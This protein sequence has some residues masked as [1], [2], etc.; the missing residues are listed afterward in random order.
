IS[1]G[2]AATISVYAL[3]R[4]EFSGVVDLIVPVSDEGSDLVTYPVTLHFTSESLA[5]LLPGMTATATF[6]VT[7]STASAAD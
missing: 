1:E 6:T 5:G 2:Q 7:E 3:S 4:Q